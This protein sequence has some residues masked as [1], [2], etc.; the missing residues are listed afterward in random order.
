M[1]RKIRVGF[2]MQLPGVW[3]K[4]QPVFEEML[5]DERFV[6][7]GIVVPKYERYDIGVRPFGEWGEEWD[8]FS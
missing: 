7:V 5:S 4:V 3:D 8:F 1:G 2:I 6:P